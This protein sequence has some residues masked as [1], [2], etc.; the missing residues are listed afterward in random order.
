MLSPEFREI[1][2][3]SGVGCARLGSDLGK[4]LVCNEKFQ[5]L[6]LILRLEPPFYP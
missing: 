4:W 5:N 1:V 6:A 2:R 3:A